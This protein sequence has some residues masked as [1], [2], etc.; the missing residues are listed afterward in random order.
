MEGSKKLKEKD[1][2]GATEEIFSKEMSE[3]FD[4]EAEQLV[5]AFHDGLERLRC[6]SHEGKFCV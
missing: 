1:H 2:D 3:Y 4:K 5:S 6:A